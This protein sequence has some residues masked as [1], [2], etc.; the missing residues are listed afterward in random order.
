MRKIA[1]IVGS[2]PQFIKAA[3]VSRALK[4]KRDVREVMIHTGQHYDVNMSEIFFRELEIP[5]PQ[6]NLE[7]GSGSHAYQTALT[8]Q[9]LEEVLI[10]ED[11]QHVVVY[12]DTNATLAGSLA[13]AKLHL[14]IAHVEAGL[15]SFKPKMPE[16]INR[17]VADHISD[18]LFAPT[19]TAM[20]N[21]AQEGLQQK[22]YEVGD[23]MYDSVLRTREIARRIVTAKQ[24]PFSFAVKQYYLATV[25][26][27]ENTDDPAR[28]KSIVDILAK[29]DLPVVFPIHPR[30]AKALQ[31]N[32]IAVDDQKVHLI[33][34]VSYFEMLF[35]TEHARKV[36]TD[37]GGVQKEA[38]FLRTPTVTLRA[39]TEWIE[40]LEGDWNIVAGTDEK[41]ILSAVR[42]QTSMQCSNAF[43]DGQAG[44]KIANILTQ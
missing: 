4:R 7:V 3:V 20:T 10:R 29:L 18:L 6:Y 8:L 42:R 27:A 34:P 1:T 13:G 44:E 28:L 39:E 17:I 5:E 33:P 23:V 31:E 19:E 30:T 25:H 22:A 12:G 43:G 9:R 40:T 41:K 14:K 16:E 11:P 2:R 32:R 38:Y 35:L 37:S 36:L 15:R 26:R 21:L 24:F